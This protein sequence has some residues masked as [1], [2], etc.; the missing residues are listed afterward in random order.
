MDANTLLADPTAIEIEKFISQDDS[1]TVI[2][3]SIQPVASCPQCG[4][5]SGSLKG[6]YLRRLADLPWHGVTVGLELKVRK[7]RCRNDFCPQKVFCER[8]PKVANLYARRT[9]RLTDV[10]TLLAFALGGRGA[11]QAAAGLQLAAVGKDVLLKL[12]RSSARSSGQANA[13]PVKVLGVD[14]FAFRKG[15]TY[16]TIL[17]DLER[18]Q[19]IDLLPDREAATLAKWLRKN[20]Q[21][22]VVTRDRSPIYAEAVR[23]GAP[24][25]VQVADRWHLLKNLRESGRRLLMCE[26]K[27]L[28]AAAR[29]LAETEGQG[30]DSWTHRRRVSLA[31]R[32][33]KID[34]G[35]ERRGL[36]HQVREL[37]RR[38]LSDRAIARFVKLH[39]ATVRRFVSAEEYPTRARQ[40]LR[41]SILD[42][43]VDYLEKRLR[44]GCRNGQQLW[45][46]IKERGYPGGT[47]MVRRY[48]FVRRSEIDQPQGEPTIAASTQQV[49]APLPVPSVEQ[50]SW[51]MMLEPNKLRPDEQKFVDSL[52]AVSSQIRELHTFSREFAEILKE[53]NESGYTDWLSRARNSQIKQI[54]NFAAGIRQ[55]AEPVRQ[56]VVSEWS[57]GQTEGQVNRL[58]A[59]KRQ[60]YGRA[61]FEL[62][63]A[64]VLNRN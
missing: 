1:I 61:N 10:L 34:G 20:P 26:H 28:E 42:P 16:G 64:R 21:V 41:P 40:A 59:I 15:A 53:K 18:R 51:W 52:S 45:R 7:F 60:M 55:D 38:G 4:L 35:N 56:A 13:S 25:A 9:K 3:H 30:E 5:S 49:E 24:E 22:E 46:E 63:R 23:V 29:H 62:L 47:K 19:P 57:N 58:K 17:V 50:V 54:R 43:Y 48:L 27:M 31:S 12:I 32:A 37:H 2:A 6:Y 14:D 36:Y 44:E 8:L 11:A 39:R 33:K